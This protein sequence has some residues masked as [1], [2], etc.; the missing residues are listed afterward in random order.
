ML[1]RGTGEGFNL[2]IPVREM[3]RWA[4]DVGVEFALSDN[5]S[6]PEEKVLWSKPIE[7][8]SSVGSVIGKGFRIRPIFGFGF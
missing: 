5:A 7:D 4:K 6:A 1:V 2:I 3:R 8:S